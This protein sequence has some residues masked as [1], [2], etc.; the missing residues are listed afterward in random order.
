MKFG[1]NRN[2][3]IFIAVLTVAIALFTYLSPQANQPEEIT[4]DE[5]IAMSQNSEIE[6][7]VVNNEELLITTTEGTEMKTTIGFLSLVDLKELGLN[8]EG[9]DWEVKPH[10]H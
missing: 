6:K 10:R 5:T 9:V 2:L 4:L 8:L 7:I 1:L 3:I